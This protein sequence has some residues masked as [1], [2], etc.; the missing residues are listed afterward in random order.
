MSPKRRNIRHEVEVLKNFKFRRHCY[1]NLC[2]RKYEKCLLANLNWEL[3][4]GEI[5]CMSHTL[6]MATSRQF[7]LNVSFYI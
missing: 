1:E 6:S 5:S 4:K 2:C 7:L 3:I